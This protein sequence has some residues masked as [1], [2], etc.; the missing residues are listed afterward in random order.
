MDKCLECWKSLFIKQLSLPDS[1][2]DILPAVVKKESL[3][4]LKDDDLNGYISKFNL[5]IKLEETSINFLNDNWKANKHIRA[6][7]RVISAKLYQMYLSFSPNPDPNAQTVTESVNF[8]QFLYENEKL[9]QGDKNMLCKL[10][11]PVLN[12]VVTQMNS[13]DQETPQNPQILFSDVI[14]ALDKALEFTA[15]E[16]TKICFKT[17]LINLQFFVYKLHEKNP[18]EYYSVL[19][20]FLTEIFTNFDQLSES[21]LKLILETIHFVP[22]DKEFLYDSIYT[23]FEIIKKTKLNRID[24]FWKIIKFIVE[25]YT[26]KLDIPDDIYLEQQDIND[27]LP[28]IEPKLAMSEEN[29]KIEIFDL[30]KSE[31][32]TPMCKN[33]KEIDYLLDIITDIIMLN[34]DSNISY[35][36]DVY[37]KETENF[38]IYSFYLSEILLF[39]IQ[40]IV[41]TKE[42]LEKY[43]ETKFFS[44]NFSRIIYDDTNN[45]FFN[46]VLGLRN[47]YFKYFGEKMNTKEVSGF[48]TEFSSKSIFNYFQVV[49]LV[50]YS[51][52][53]ISKNTA[54]YMNYLDMTSDYFSK[55]RLIKFSEKDVKW[56]NNLYIYLISFIKYM[57]DIYPDC[58]F[59]KSLDSVI[60]L[61]FESNTQEIAINIINTC[62]KSMYCNKLIQIIN[63]IRE[64]NL[65]L[66][67]ILIILLEKVEFNDQILM[68][69]QNLLKEIAETINTYPEQDLIT[70][71]L[72]FVARNCR[73]SEFIPKFIN[74][75]DD[76]IK[77]IQIDDKIIEY[78]EII[79]FGQ[80]IVSSSQNPVILSNPSI[81]PN[82]I[83]IL[84]DS[85]KLSEIFGFLL[86]CCQKSY[87]NTLKICLCENEK[88]GK[89]ESQLLN[90]INQEANTKEAKER[91]HN[92]ETFLRG[93]LYNN[94]STE[95]FLGLMKAMRDSKDNEI[96]HRIIGLLMNAADY[97]ALEVMGWMPGFFSLYGENVITVN[98]DL[99][100]E[101]SLFS[102]VIKFIF[103]DVYRD[104]KPTKTLFVDAN[105]TLSVFVEDGNLK[106][107]INNGEKTKVCRFEIRSAVFCSVAFSVSKIQI[108]F[109]VC[110]S[111][112]ESTFVLDLR[113]MKFKTNKI[114][115]GKFENQENLDQFP[116]NI[117]SINILQ[118]ARTEE[119]L[120]DICRQSPSEIKKQNGN[121]FL[122]LN[123][124]NW[125]V[126]NSE[127]FS[128]PDTIKSSEQWSMK[129]YLITPLQIQSFYQAIHEC[130]GLSIFLSFFDSIKTDKGETDDKLAYFRSLITIIS[131]LMRDPIL[132]QGF[133]KEKSFL[134]M[135]QYLLTFP[136]EVFCESM[137]VSLSYFYNCITDEEGKFSFFK[138]IYANP[139]IWEKI[140]DKEQRLNFIQ[141]VTEISQKSNFLSRMDLI[142]KYINYLEKE[143]RF[144]T[145]KTE[146][147]KEI[148]G[149]IEQMSID[150]FTQNDHYFILSEAVKFRKE[151]PVF[152]KDLLEF[153]YDFHTKYPQHN[154]FLTASENYYHPFVELLE[155][156]LTENL[157][158]NFYYLTNFV[159]FISSIQYKFQCNN[160]NIR[161]AALSVVLKMNWNF[162]NYP[163]KSE[164]TTLF[165]EISKENDKLLADYFP[166]ICHLAISM[167]ETDFDE[168]I[169]FFSQK[170]EIIL[171]ECNEWIYWILYLLLNRS[172]IGCYQKIVSLIS[173]YYTKIPV[174]KQSLVADVVSVQEDKTIPVLSSLHF[175]MSYLSPFMDG[176]I[177]GKTNLTNVSTDGHP[178]L[179]FFKECL[180]Y[181]SPNIEA[182]LNLMILALFENPIKENEFAKIPTDCKPLELSIDVDTITMRG[183]NLELPLFNE[184]LSFEDIWY[185][186]F[187]IWPNTQGKC[188]RALS[189]ITGYYIVDI[190]DE[191]KLVKL[192]VFL[193]NKVDMHRDSFSLGLKRRTDY[194]INKNN[195]SELRKRLSDLI[196]LLNANVSQVLLNFKKKYDFENADFPLH[197]DFNEYSEESSFK[198][199]DLVYHSDLAK[200]KDLFKSVI[201]KLNSLRTINFNLNISEIK[202]II[203]I[204]KLH[205]YEKFRKY[206]KKMLSNDCHVYKVKCRFDQNF[207]VTSPRVKI[208]R[209]LITI[210]EIELINNCKFQK[211]VDN[212]IDSFLTFYKEKF[213]IIYQKSDKSYIIHRFDP[214]KIISP[215]KDRY[216]FLTNKQRVYDIT[217]TGNVTEDLTQKLKIE[218]NE[219]EKCLEK[220]KNG[221]LSVYQY[222]LI[223]NFY[224]GFTMRT[225]EGNCPKYSEEK[226]FEENINFEEIRLI[227]ETKHLVNTINLSP[228][229]ITN[230]NTFN[231]KQN[232]DLSSA[233]S[234]RKPIKMQSS[235]AVFENCSVEWI[236]GKIITPKLMESRVCLDFCYNEILGLVA[237]LD[238][239]EQITIYDSWGDKVGEYT[240]T[241]S[242]KRVL[243]CASLKAFVVQ[244]ANGIMLYKLNGCV[245]GN[246]SD[247]SIKDIEIYDRNDSSSPL[248]FAVT[249]NYIYW[250]EIS[251]LQGANDLSKF[252]KQELKLKF[253]KVNFAANNTSVT[254]TFTIPNSPYK[255]VPFAVQISSREM[256]F[257]Q[258]NEN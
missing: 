192:L 19:K 240:V 138:N 46:Y 256:N 208:E 14:R 186:I 35:V 25:N 105:K 99:N 72:E 30:K 146:I 88:Y 32:F 161:D 237:V 59:G 157:T 58:L 76:S 54:P 234:H 229:K 48:V 162:V 155:N 89:I 226:G 104:Q 150:N 231:D 135:K 140:K 153:L 172:Q 201:E 245:F 126:S 247:N 232:I 238:N 38:S 139:D 164:V 235:F 121:E 26:K 137:F 200:S 132:A 156:D 70:S 73:N 45:E 133:F 90:I 142:F 43:L 233:Y 185:L 118:G 125:S 97:Q 21:N 3:K 117:S 111:E 215:S 228:L 224:K 179:S 5:E 108:V 221:E 50:V 84:Y 168:F 31:I 63:Q 136:S 217:I 129:G 169:S 41:P 258:Q 100:L 36:F 79:C 4:D 65:N 158:N 148:F 181:Q 13:F 198:K 81:L 249:D 61:L 143:Y 37:L 252:H 9:N 195:S 184:Y 101:K 124:V 87:R 6:C 202:E 177:I 147:I 80:K 44:D 241:P 173:I 1:T 96:R 182:I 176:N 112:N 66:I 166:L 109:T 243:F 74:S 196:V 95:T 244:Y 102:F 248:L 128:T 255:Q 211:S 94:V 225:N 154:K 134:I 220:Y 188:N 218:E 193:T 210:P 18:K 159:K 227:N 77:K 216:V 257:N 22:E 116:I 62:V 191:T 167:S 170:S 39:C 120:L 222:Y 60:D 180:H 212:V 85:E 56:I 11:R 246:V 219:E 20:C 207:D 174:K 51:I 197:K 119:Q 52:N 71:V 29:Q 190:D 115:I 82:I 187:E 27:Y 16:E 93:L 131:S 69:L 152:S 28:G 34:A 199:S 47:E 113:R 209:Q 49:P 2:N 98:L 163:V 214:L 160:S 110:Q 171:N 86:F 33:H 40:K 254:F 75:I 53:N 68:N 17:D 213:V 55:T 251:D 204:E 107:Q 123:A 122:S 239:H 42:M 114:F 12:C 64:G 151:L 57:I 15:D 24:D 165:K 223:S 8:I 175:I 78:L 230:L 127:K 130:G 242:A 236:P 178:L 92:A 141:K 103:D 194:E 7:F 189:Y 144:A 67:K 91:Q 250:A 203:S 206:E 10:I 253:E 106:C 83:N 145:E 183:F 23:L 149:I 205:D